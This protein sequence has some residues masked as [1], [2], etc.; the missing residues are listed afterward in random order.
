MPGNDALVS[1][2][3]ADAQ[4]LAAGVFSGAGVPPAQAD[5]AAEVLA[6]TEGMG[7]TTHGLARVAD[8]IGRIRAG[9]ID[10]LATLEVLR[11][12]PALR[13]IDGGNGLG[14]AVMRA[15]LD[16]AMEAARVCG[17]GAVF[18]KGSGHI[19][20]LAPYLYLSAE[21]GFAALLTT[22][23][24]PMIAP[25][26]GRAA[27]IGNNPIGFSI[28]DP[29]GNHVLLDMALSVV[30]R[31]RVRAAER[32]GQTIP[33]SWATDAEG[34]P[35]TDPTQA[36]RGLMRAIGG[37]KGANLALCL[38]LMASALSGSAMLNEIPNAATTPDIPQNLG[39]MLVL[40]N[41][42]VLA[43]EPER[44][45]RL[46]AARG[47]IAGT[48]PVDPSAPVRMP[49]ARALASLRTART[50]GLRVAPDLLEELRAYS[51][52]GRA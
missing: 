13:R 35:T 16:E 38:D 21:A 44:G 36:M 7:I 34:Q 31:S 3:L 28:P 32:A 46:A 4:T 25:A 41:A 12:M 29:G 33:E 5:A 27:R 30:S 24:A 15:A 19:G 23:T 47:V 37:D 43:S 17:A 42:G 2:S 9:G 6:L 18:V 39:Q 14:P 22:N 8:Y 48:P 40:V 20:A 51:G 50:D 26:G 10:P 49:G 1:L 45:A 52:A 11:P